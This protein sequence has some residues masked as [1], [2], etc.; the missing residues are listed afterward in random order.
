MKGGDLDSIDWKLFLERDLEF[1]I[2]ELFARLYYK[3]MKEATGF[4]FVKRLIFFKNGNGR[5]Y[6]SKKESEGCS[7]HFRRLIEDNDPRIPGWIEKEK[8]THKLAE[9]ISSIDDIEEKIDTFLEIML[10]NTEIPFRLL[11]PLEKM[12]GHEELKEKLER[13]RLKAFRPEIMENLFGK[14]YLEISKEHGIT[15]GQASLLTASELVDLLKHGKL[16]PVEELEKRNNGCYLYC[17]G[18]D[19][20]YIFADEDKL[21]DIDTSLE[22][23]EG[24][25]AFKGK[26]RGTAKIVNSIK[27]MGK[28]NEGDVLVS[29]N[30][31][32]SI[33][34]AIH[35]A[36]AIVADEGGITSH[37]AIVSRELKK[38][39]IVGTKI[40]TKIFK[41]GDEVEVD[42]HKGIVKIMKD[43]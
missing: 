5:W 18:D 33:M 9:R 40:A 41:D 4:G 28:F 36:S 14:L 42:A 17:N 11:L 7:N 39:C 12:E 13:I 30:T 32:P 37:A 24:T 19:I 1:F 10:F 38:P 20:E 25:P 6:L 21:L 8:E 16:V 27:Q 26:V 22:E 43:E 31:S 29:I 3:N 23:C 34:P 15:K 35:K 2:A